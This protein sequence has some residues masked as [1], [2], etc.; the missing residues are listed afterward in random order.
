MNTFVFLKN[1]FT[2]PRRTGFEHSRI[3][4]RGQL[5]D[6][7]LSLQAKKSEEFVGQDE[8]DLRRV[9]NIFGRMTS[10]RMMH[11]FFIR[12]RANQRYDQVRCKTVRKD[13]S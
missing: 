13:G 1:A 11:L 5:P 10:A 8:I 12:L 6:G 9:A 3:S 4:L 7:A 2:P